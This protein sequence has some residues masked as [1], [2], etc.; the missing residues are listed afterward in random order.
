MKDRM[1][2]EECG[3][4][5][6]N[7]QSRHLFN[8]CRRPENVSVNDPPSICC[9]LHDAGARIGAGAS[10]APPNKKKR[11]AL[12]REKHRRRQFEGYPLAIRLAALY[13]VHR[14]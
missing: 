7:T 9:S 12:T 14:N 11:L 5:D 13:T 10:I 2:F 6:G 3:C 8:V 4:G 1:T